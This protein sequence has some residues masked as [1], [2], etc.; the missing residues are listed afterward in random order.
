M[1]KNEEIVRNAMQVIWNECDISRVGEF[2]SKDFKADYPHT[3]WGLGLEGICLLATQVHKDLPNYEENIEELIDA[4]NKIIVTLAI[5]GN[6]PG[7]G[8]TI[9]FRDVT[10]LTLKD[11]KIISQS[12]VGDLLTLY[13]KLGMI[14]FP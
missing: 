11:G 9:I 3:D 2:Y 5:S 13:I 12:G 1:A 14:D 4:G 7:N 10:I 8:K 6:H